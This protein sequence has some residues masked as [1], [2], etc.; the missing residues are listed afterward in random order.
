MIKLVKI[1]NRRRIQLVSRRVEQGFH[2]DRAGV[3]AVS[4]EV[5]R[6]LKKTGVRRDVGLRIRL[7]MEELLLR[8][9]EHFHEEVDGRLIIRRRFGV[10]VL[11]FRYPGER[12]DPMQTGEDETGDVAR[13]LLSRIGLAPEWSF[14]AGV[15]ELTLRGPRAT[16]RS[17]IWLI[18]AVILT[19]LF[20]F[21]PLVLPEEVT[22]GVLNYILQPV[23]D[24]FMRALNTFVGLMIFTSVI[25]GIC[26][27]GNAAD[28]SRVGRYVIGR[29]AF[30][31]FVCTAISAVLLFPFFGFH[32]GETAGG[33]SHVSTLVNLIFEIVPSDPLS[34]FV[35]GDLLQILFLAVIFGTVLLLLGE[36]TRG[37]RE[38]VLQLHS[39]LM[40]AIEGICKLLPLFVFTSLTSLLWKNGAG[41]FARLWMP[42]L[43]FIGVA[44]ILLGGKLLI[45]C[46][47]LRISPILVLSKIKSSIFTGLLTASESAALGQILDINEKKL[48]IAPEI[49]RFS[50]PFASLLADPGTGILYTVIL[51]YLASVHGVP[52]N[53][54]WFLILW[55]MCSVFA[56]ATPPVSGGPLVCAG[57]LMTQMSIPEAGLGMA[58]ILLIALDFF[59][60]ATKIGFMHLEILQEANHLQK[61]DR[62]KLEEKN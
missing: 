25:S 1:G 48:G 57:L 54:G 16:L 20:G 12:F 22:S 45:T 19:V 2:L 28:F 17:E 58:S 26:S 55:V 8:I 56:I 41:V 61:L 50:L 44:V 13:Q 47:N 9:C 62:K 42:I 33:S 40:Q 27:V 34:P 52:V 31:P 53:P 37:I 14:H 29:Q 4:E 51:F 6:W 35:S 43:L 18:G 21:L 60:T 32:F 23:S 7:T 38:L 3:D 49:D 46:R 15:N 24:A 59:S 11:Q 30:V 10:P 5:D 36:K 39:I